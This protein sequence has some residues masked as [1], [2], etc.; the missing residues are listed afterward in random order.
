M[1]DDL[2]REAE[3]F[4]AE[5]RKQP[6]VTDDYDERAGQIA[7]IR[8]NPDGTRDVLFPPV[9]T[10][11]RRRYPRVSRPLEIAIISLF[12]L[13]AIALVALAVIAVILLR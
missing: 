9:D 12:L 4:L 11:T 8:I 10:S 1:N 13:A 5:H 6:F 2:I 3:E 7:T